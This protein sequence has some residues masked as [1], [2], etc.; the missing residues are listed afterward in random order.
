MFRQHPLAA[1]CNRCRFHTTSTSGCEPHC[2]DFEVAA[3]SRVADQV[4]ERQY[5][6]EAPVVLKML[7]P[8]EVRIFVVAA[9]EC[10]DR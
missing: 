4:Q 5:L 7:M 3:P 9:D 10:Q 2:V 1:Y 8:R 6:L